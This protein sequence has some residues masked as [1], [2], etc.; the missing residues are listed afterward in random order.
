MKEVVDGFWKILCKKDVS[1]T[2]SQ[3]GVVVFEGDVTT[4]FVL[5]VK[6]LTEFKWNNLKKV[7]LGLVFIFSEWKT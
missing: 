3:V 1:V 2:Q 5:V 7:I 4:I 6:L